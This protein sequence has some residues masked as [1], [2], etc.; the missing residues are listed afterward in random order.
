M[1]IERALAQL[2][3][4]VW[5]A[6]LAA[7]RRCGCHRHGHDSSLPRSAQP[8]ARRD[9][10]ASPSSSPTSPRTPG[11]CCAWPPAWA[12]RPTSS[13]PPAFP[14]SD[15]A[16]RR[17]GMDYLDH[18]AIERHVSWAAFDAA[19]RAERAAPGAGDDLGGHALH[20]LSAL[21]RA[22]SCW[23]AANRR[24]S[25]PRCTRRRMRR[26]GIPMR[27]G[28]AVPQRRGRSGHDHGRGLAA[29]RLMAIMSPPPARLRERAC[30]TETTPAQ[31]SA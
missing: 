1:L 27:P 15:R 21:R 17:A 14:V 30:M 6:A 9:R 19:R 7:D 22:T 2:S 3:R 8:Q 23:S 13:S 24:A 11:R 4:A 10:S 18:V 12:S 31:A 20:R 28:L 5:N 25:R 26:V 16:F 29:N